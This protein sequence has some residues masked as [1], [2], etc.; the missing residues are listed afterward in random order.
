MISRSMAIQPP[1]T[2]REPCAARDGYETGRD[3]PQSPRVERSEAG[4]IWPRAGAL[5]RAK[6]YRLKR[7]GSLTTKTLQIVQKMVD[8]TGKL[9][10]AAG[11][12]PRGDG[13]ASPET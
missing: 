10:W 9:V 1:D 3:G 12:D 6:E 5:G 4:P 7:K 2:P 13:H 11:S 8:E